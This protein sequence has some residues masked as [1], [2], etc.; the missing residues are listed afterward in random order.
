MDQRRADAILAENEQ[1]RERV[2]VL[3]GLLMDVRPLPP[4]WCLTGSEARIFGVLVNRPVATKECLY[5]ALYD[6]HQDGGFT[7]TIV[8]PH[9]SHLRR[10]L[11]PFGISIETRRGYGYLL[12]ETVRARFRV[13]AAPALPRP[14]MVAAA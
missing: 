7:D 12:P 14:R 2:A 4:E 6:V 3:E 1:L 9:V 5:R 11:K 10:K 8:E 13:A